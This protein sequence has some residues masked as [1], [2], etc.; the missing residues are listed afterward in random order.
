MALHDNSRGW[1]ITVGLTRE[2]FDAW[3]TH[4]STPFVDR[5]LT[6]TDA[7]I[8]LDPI[9]PADKRALVAARLTSPP[10]AAQREADGVSDELFPLSEVDLDDVAQTAGDYPRS[11]IIRARE[12]F[13]AQC[14]QAAVPAPPPTLDDILAR[15][16]DEALARIVPD[17]LLIDKSV[18]ADRLAE[19]VEAV[20]AAP[21]LC[22]RKS[23]TWSNS[24]AFAARTRP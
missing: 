2:P 22:P 16:F 8:G 20:C 10:I 9:R 15:E 18:L 4:L 1:F 11:V 21:H 19:V 7:V 6:D 5:F 13:R 12:R 17:A 24:P 23:A 14:L 3:R